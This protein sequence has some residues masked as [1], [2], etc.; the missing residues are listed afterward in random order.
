MRNGYSTR[1]ASCFRHGVAIKESLRR[2]LQLTSEGTS[3]RQCWTDYEGF[4]PS[5]WK[6]KEVQCAAP[7]LLNT[8]LPHRFSWTASSMIGCIRVMLTL[9]K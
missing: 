8:I 6:E 7:T 9:S 4:H 2:K 5:V 3:A 1:A